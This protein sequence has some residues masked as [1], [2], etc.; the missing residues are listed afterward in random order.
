MI[1]KATVN[2]IEPIL[3]ITKA[4]A[5]FMIG[6]GILQWNET[7]PN[8]IAFENDIKR[9]ELYIIENL[10]E[11]I[12]CLV[13]STLMDI[14]YQSVKWLTPNTKNLYIH[15]LAVHPN[16]QGQGFARK[17]MY[18][19][20]EFAIKNNYTSIRL[21][22]FSKNKRNQKFYELRGYEKLGAIFFPK[23]SEF[24]FYC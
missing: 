12:G 18:F 4:C 14:E 21:D 24:P 3:K 23:Q 7:Y 20:E 8:K 16:Y 2:D 13:I 9:G 17:L 10:N 22:T 1:R 15:R 5:Q 19:A 6:N 11:V